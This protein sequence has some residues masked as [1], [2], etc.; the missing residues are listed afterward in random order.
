MELRLPYD[1]RN[2]RLSPSDRNRR[3]SY[4]IL[5]CSSGRMGQIINDE[6]LARVGNHS[7][8]FPMPIAKVEV[9]LRFPFK[10][11]LVHKIVPVVLA[12][13]ASACFIVGPKRDYECSVLRRGVVYA[14]QAWKIVKLE[15]S[16]P[17]RKRLHLVQ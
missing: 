3:N 7:Q 8:S 15:L 1:T 12:N 16:A 4:R 2:K 6:V 13:T 9:P 11:E 17:Q 14:G 5:V 10:F